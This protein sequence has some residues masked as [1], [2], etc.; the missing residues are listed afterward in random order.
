MP[1]IPLLDVVGRAASVAP[2]HMGATVVNVGVSFGLTVMV[3]VVVVAHWPAA[4]VNVYVVVTVL[5]NAGDQEPLIPL[6]D[7]VGK[8]GSVA[9]EHIGATAVNVGVTF[10]L[11]VIVNVVVVAH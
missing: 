7:V 6:L 8:V 5:F 9:P 10:A 11:T 4:G 2:E 1:V 3:N